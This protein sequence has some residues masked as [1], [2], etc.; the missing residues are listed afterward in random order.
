M[1]GVL[2]TV[3]GAHY[4]DGYRLDY[5]D[6]FKPWRRQYAAGQFDEPDARNGVGDAKSL[7]SDGDGD[8]KGNGQAKV[9]TRDVGQ[10]MV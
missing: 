2:V 4:Y 10:D 3:N 6:G 9:T 8:E 5:V 7:S 1:K